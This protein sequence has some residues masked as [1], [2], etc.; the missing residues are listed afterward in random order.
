MKQREKSKIKIKLCGLMRPSDIETANLLKPDYVG[1]VFAKK[2]RRYVS[3]ERVRTLKELLHPE[4]TAVGVFVDEEPEAVAEWLS[5]GIIDMAQLHGRE[6]EAYIKRLRGLTDRPLIK[7]FSV[8][9][10]RDITEACASTAD[11]VL[12]DA[13]EGGTGTAFDRELLTGMNRPYFL[14]GGLDVS[15]V[16]EA[17]KR[18]RPYAVDVSSGIETDGCKDAGKMQAFVESVRKYDAI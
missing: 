2:S 14:A 17:V 6:D 18:W 3:L 12:L 1:F 11:F 9:N 7:A 4:I 15:T 10:E 16:G 8:R 5:A 13:G